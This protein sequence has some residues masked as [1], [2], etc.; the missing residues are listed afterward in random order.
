MGVWI[1]IRPETMINLAVP[2]LLIAAG[3]AI[4][5]QNLLMSIM[6]A[7]ASSILVPLIL[8]S[9]VG[10]VALVSLLVWREGADGF[11]NIVASFRPWNLLPGLLGSFFVFASILGYARLGA[12]PTIAILVSSQLAFG[13]LADV[14]RVPD[15]GNH[16]MMLSVSACC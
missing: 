8:N 11:A 3:A 14:L 1:R 5:G 16:G 7:S 9:A 12:A 6:A 2:V 13:M 4:V 15:A 10:L